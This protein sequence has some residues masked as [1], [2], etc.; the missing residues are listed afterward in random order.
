VTLNVNL[1]EVLVQA[2]KDY[3]Y[4]RVTF[5]FKSKV[6]QRHGSMRDV[7]RVIRTDLTSGNPDA[8]KDGLSN[9]LYWGFYTR[10][11]I[12][13]FRVTEFRKG[14]TEKK[15]DEARHLFKNLKETGVIQIKN[16]HLPQFS[17]LSFVSKARMFL[18]PSRYVTLDLSLMRLRDARVVTIFREIKQYKTQIPITGHNELCYERWCELCRKLVHDSFRDGKVLAVDIERGIFHLVKTGRI[19]L[20]ADILSSV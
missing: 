13:D 18:D 3:D 19:D 10:G 5:D 4:P 9:V 6:E 14:V 7:E 20:A 11:G 1:R 8:V 2:I 17:G 15:L 16:L 12:R